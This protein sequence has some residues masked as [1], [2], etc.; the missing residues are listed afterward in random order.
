MARWIDPPLERYEHRPAP[1]R[2]EPSPEPQDAVRPAQG[3]FCAAALSAPLW[4]LI[5]WAVRRIL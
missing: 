1:A 4:L 3:V 2:A 5:W